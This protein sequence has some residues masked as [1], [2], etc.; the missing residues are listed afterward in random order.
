MVCRMTEQY[1]IQY[2]EGQINNSLDYIM[3]TEDIERI[4]TSVFHN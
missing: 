2:S 1:P 3:L 4:L